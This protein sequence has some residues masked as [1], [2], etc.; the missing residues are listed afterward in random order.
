MNPVRDQYDAY[1]YPPRN[2]EDAVLKFRGARQ[3]QRNVAE[4]A[5]FPESIALE[6]FAQFG[7]PVAFHEARRT[8]P[9]DE[10][11]ARRAANFVG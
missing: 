4:G 7:M 1:P 3:S 2:P 5:L 8:S 9:C 10:L 11:P 6:P